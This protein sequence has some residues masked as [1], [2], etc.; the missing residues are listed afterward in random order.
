M[1]ETEERKSPKYILTHSFLGKREF[2][3][4]FMWYVEYNRGYLIASSLYAWKLSH[5]TG[6]CPR[7]LC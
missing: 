6:L 2:H 5:L 1:K 3:F 4:P 7:I